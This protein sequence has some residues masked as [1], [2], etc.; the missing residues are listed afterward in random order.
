MR[1]TGVG[2]WVVFNFEKLNIFAQLFYVLN[3]QFLDL[4]KEP[5]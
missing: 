4:K 5:L 1:R 2:K 3:L